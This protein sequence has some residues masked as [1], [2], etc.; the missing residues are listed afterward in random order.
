MKL[1]FIRHGKTDWN[2][3]GRIQGS[4]DIELNEI[5]INQAMELS[6]KL[7]GLNYNFKKIY[8]S[9]QKRALKTAKIIS[10][11]SNVPYII[12]E[13]LKEIN[14][15]QW[16]GLIWK[17]VEDKYPLEYKE[18]KGNRR[19]NPP[20]NGESYED[21][22]QRVIIALHKIINENTDDV[23]IVTHSA[24]IMCLQ[25]YITN[26]SFN[27]MLKFKTNNAEITEIDSKF[28]I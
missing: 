17:D 28:I 15:G 13:D 7:K 3:Q 1:I 21:M 14:M 18:W 6:N 23:V 19:F 9:P 4:H 26:T 20:P 24:V 10:E 16:E 11:I 8:T 22:M 5:G 12:A 2:V 27:E 25:C